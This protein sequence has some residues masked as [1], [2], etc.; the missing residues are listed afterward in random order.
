MKFLLFLRNAFI[1]ALQ[2]LGFLWIADGLR[3]MYP[4]ISVIYLGVVAIWVGHR[5]YAAYESE[6]SEK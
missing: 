1:F 5:L 2:L 3:M 6:E 4:P